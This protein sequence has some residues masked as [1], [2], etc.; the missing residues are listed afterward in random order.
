MVQRLEGFISADAP[1]A[2]AEF[3]TRLLTFS[4]SRLKLNVD[5]SATGEVWVEIVHDRGIPVPGYTMAESISVERNQIAAPVCWK[6]WES[7]AELAGRPVRLHFRLRACK[8]YAFQF[9]AEGQP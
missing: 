6:E 2:G 1:Y 9:C 4:G 8:L 3:T 7:V 5:C